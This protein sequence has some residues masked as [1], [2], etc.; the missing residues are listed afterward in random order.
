[1]SKIGRVFA[2]V[3]GVAATLLLTATVPAEEPGPSPGGAA[4]Y[5][6]HKVADG[7]VRLDTATG[8]VALCSQRP[9]GWACVAAPEDRTAFENEIA[10]LRKE[11]AALKQALLSR[12]LPLP[13]GTMPE[14]QPGDGGDSVILRLPNNADLDRVMAFIG[15]VWHSLVEAV[16]NAQNALLHKS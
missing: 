8:A 5:S 12:G 1:M 2:A 6:F 13:P 14:A 3:A 16:G 11:N 10:R 4:R 7:F 15:R 9:V